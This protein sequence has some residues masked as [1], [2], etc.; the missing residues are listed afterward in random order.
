[1]PTSDPSDASAHPAL[2]ALFG[3]QRELLDSWLSEL[4]VEEDMSWGLVDTTVLKAR[5]P[6]GHMVVK[7]GGPDNHHI[8]REIGAHREWTAPLARKCRTSR[9]LHADEPA[10]LLVTTYLPGRLATGWLTRTAPFEA[11]TSD[12]PHCGLRPRTLSGWRPRSFGGIR[13]RRGPSSAGTGLI[14]VSLLPGSASVSELPSAQ[15]CGHS[16]SAMKTSKPRA[17]E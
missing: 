14:P 16:R 7:A 15:L 6:G 3:R 9:L 12:V 13:D 2:S 5:T 1:M 17:T 4:D 10:D 11:S 8:G